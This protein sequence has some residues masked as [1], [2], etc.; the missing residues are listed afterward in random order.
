MDFGAIMQTLNSENGLA[1]MMQQPAF[2]DEAGNQFS[3]ADL[4]AD[5]V[6]IL[7]MDTKRMGEAVGVDISISKMTPERA[8]ELLQGVAKGDDL[9][10][11]D[12][13]DQIE[14]QRM[15]ILSELEGEDSVV[16]YSEMKQ[17]MLYSYPDEMEGSV[18]PDP[19]LLEQEVSD[20]N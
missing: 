8:A 12:I 5:V 9:G 15:T 13:F 11:V 6:N 17:G 2:E 18:E 1:K 4:I 14:D 3:Q 10:L 16:E 7:R 20:E 19:E